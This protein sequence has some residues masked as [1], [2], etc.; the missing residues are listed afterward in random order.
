MSA[1][2]TPSNS[3]AVRKS[4]NDDAEQSVRIVFR[5]LRTCNAMTRRNT[6]WMDEM[7]VTTEQC[8]V[9]STLSSRSPNGMTVNELCEYLMVSRQ[10]LNGV[11]NRLDN[12]GLTH[13]ASDAS[14]GRVKRVKLTPRGE[15]SVSQIVPMLSAF[16]VSALNDFTAD[17]LNLFAQMI[18]RLRHNIIQQPEPVEISG[19]G[20]E[21]STAEL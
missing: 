6:A 20:G 16:A 9:L 8:S 19:R 10:G 15:A 7:G 11:L 18:S 2:G 3:V 4:P 1:R 12:M 14:D 17:E 21:K 13:R 5:L